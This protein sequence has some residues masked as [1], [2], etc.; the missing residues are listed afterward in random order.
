[1]S[2]ASAGSAGAANVIALL[3]SRRFHVT[4]AQCGGVA[5]AVLVA[6]AL[7]FGP[8]KGGA[9]GGG[10]DSPPPAPAIA[11]SDAGIKVMNADGTNV[12]T[13]VSVRRQ[14]QARAPAW[15]PDGAEI[16]YWARTGS[17]AALWAVPVSGG[18]PRMVAPVRD[19]WLPASPD[20][21][22]SPAADGRHKI[23]FCDTGLDPGDRDVYIVNPDGT[24]LLN[25]TASPGAEE[26]YAA[27]SRDG[28]RLAV[29]RDGEL[30]VFEIG[31]VNGAPAI[32]GEASLFFQPGTPIHGPRWANTSDS[33]TFDLVVYPL[34]RIAVLDAA[35]P[36]AGPALLT[37]VATTDERW[38]GF[39]PDDSRIVFHRG[40]AGIV[41]M[42]ADGSG[43]TLINSR[44]LDP[45]W[46][47]NP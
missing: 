35:D 12:R 23:A 5:A 30:V 37:P 25:L 21:S 20:W 26:W 47:R 31:L 41:V 28:T 8:G 6:G 36:G 16:A 24:G 46:R 13:L 45:S 44:G 3:R 2:G 22:Y 14:D 40:N 15:S 38:P 10:G 29:V 9:G 19:P 42:N 18:T 4:N 1:M 34:L 17:T 27:W 7:G 32:I 33:I 43:Q 39:S 11:F